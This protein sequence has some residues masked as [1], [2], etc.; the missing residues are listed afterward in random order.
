LFKRNEV[1]TV[2]GMCGT[3]GNLGLLIFSLL[4][5]GLVATVGYTPF[6]VTL[7][8]LDL[9]GAVLLWMLVRENTPERRD[10]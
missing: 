1:A 8:V 5:G 9:V 3:C 4:I 2:A 10:A 7:G 6:F